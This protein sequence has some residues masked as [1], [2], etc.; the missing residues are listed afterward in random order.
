MVDL[1]ARRLSGRSVA[2][3][4]LLNGHRASDVSG[5]GFA[6]ALLRADAPAGAPGSPWLTAL[7]DAPTAFNQGFN[8]VR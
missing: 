8:K 3:M 1:L 4:L 6:A 7:S 5:E 2:G